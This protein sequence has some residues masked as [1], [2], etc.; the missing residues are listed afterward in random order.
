V[1][2][3]WFPDGGQRDFVNHA[4]ERFEAPRSTMG[5]RPQVSV[6]RVPIE[7]SDICVTHYYGGMQIYLKVDYI[8]SLALCD[9][10]CGLCAAESGLA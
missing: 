6:A 9:F 10:T 7:P 2:A 1:D 3:Y 4:I 8:R 5:Q